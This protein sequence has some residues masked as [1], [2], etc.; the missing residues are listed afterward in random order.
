MRAIRQ[1]QKLKRAD[2]CPE[3][4]YNV[5]LDCWKLDSRLRPTASQVHERMMNLRG[6]VSDNLDWPTASSSVDVPPASE[7]CGLDLDSSKHVQ[8]FRQAEI[9]RDQIVLGRQLGKGA[10]GAVY[11][12]R[13]DGR[14]V[15]IKMLISEASELQEKF[16]LEGKLLCA[17]RHPHVVSLLH[18]QTRSMPFAIVVELM[19]GDLRTYLREHQESGVEELTRVCHQIASAMQYLSGFNVI[20]RDLAARF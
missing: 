13:I 17:L 7:I 20:H 14:D 12:S 10:F 5:M 8:A 2:D 16:L 1:K 4:V 9:G 6:A 15:A 18:V 3:D 19:A 11:A